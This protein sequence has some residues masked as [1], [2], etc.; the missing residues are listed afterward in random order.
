M[1]FSSKPD[2]GTVGKYGYLVKNRWLL[3]ALRLRDMLPWPPTKF[4]VTPE[5]PS[6]VLLSS[7]G[8]LGDCVI[9]TATLNLVR[10]LLPETQIG[11]LTGSWNSVI[12]REDPRVSWLHTIDH[13]I[14]DRSVRSPQ[15]KFSRYWRSRRTALQEIRDIGYDAAVDLFY[16]F[17]PAGPIFYAAKIPKRI[18]YASGGFRRYLTHPHPWVLSEKHVARYQAELLESLGIERTQLHAEMRGL[19]MSLGA[20]PEYTER[21]DHVIIHTGTG[22]AQREWPEDRWSSVASAL[23]KRGIKVL[24][25]GRGDAEAARC[26]RIESAVPNVLNLCDKLDWKSLCK[27][28]A[29][30]R[31]LIG[32]NS[33]SGHLAACF[34]VPTITIWAGV[35][36]PKHWQPLGNN[37]TILHTPQPCLPCYEWRGCSGMQCIRDVGVTEVLAA[38]YANL[39]IV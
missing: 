12:F 26:A 24:L 38:V 9:A 21:S 39:G 8:H 5:P 10:R 13:W 6:R 23:T 30:S 19:R 4:K 14:L 15:E 18:G 1:I 16:F 28:I 31:L 34:G 11:V 3:S 17:P 27:T 20:M 25:T 22:S 33:L 35:V 29:T 2:Y 36:N 32:V 37:A 7:F